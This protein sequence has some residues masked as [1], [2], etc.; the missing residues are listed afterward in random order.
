M[1]TIFAAECRGCDFR[2]GIVGCS[3][4]A[5]RPVEPPDVFLW[6]QFAWC[7]SCR[8]VVQA[9]H[10]LTPVES[11]EWIAGSS[12]RR[13]RL[14]GEH[15]RR[16]M[17]SRQSPAHCLRCGSIE[18][19]PASADCTEWLTRTLTAIPHP[20]CGGMISLQRNGL[21]RVPAK[22]RV[23]SPEGEFVTVAEGIL[24]PGRGY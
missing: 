19:A 10:L 8:E 15:Y 17:A 9:E 22:T 7:A 21:A 20:V 2:Q 12:G 16:M 24:L 11:E 23:Y 4:Y 18:V 1:A 5:Y 14:D 3:D 6:T 13:A